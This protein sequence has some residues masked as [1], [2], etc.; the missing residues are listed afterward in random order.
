M[1][2]AANTSI[3][4]STGFVAAISVLTLGMGLLTG[5][6]F[7]VALKD[8]HHQ[9]Q[10]VK[11]EWGNGNLNTSNSAYAEGDSVPHR[12][13]FTGVPLNTTI[14][15][16]IRYE[17]T[18]G[19]K[20]AF[21]FL[22]SY[23]RTEGPLSV[24]GPNNLTSLNEMSD[25]TTLDIPKDGSIDTDDPPV[26]TEGVQQFTIYGSFSG[27]AYVMSGPSADG[28]D[29][30]ITI[31]IPGVTGEIL[32]A[33]GGHLAI[34]NQANWGP[35]NGAGSIS[36][37]PYHQNGSGFIDED[38]DL[39]YNPGEE[40]KFGAGDR[41]INAGAVSFIE[42]GIEIEKAT[43]GQDAD[44]PP[45]PYIPVGDSVTWTYVVTN[46]GNVTLNKVAQQ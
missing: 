14:V 31:V 25:R 1:D 41:S 20:Y 17:F 12:Y 19:G 11:L 24:F 22:T 23:D 18:R 27:P 33:W 8:Q 26:W 15:M 43:N 16:D 40:K 30:V 28:T 34:G 46:T 5:E 39:I 2:R 9:F 37:S 3:G 36:G 35:G 21:D 6:V 4:K 29:K 7:A 10:N 32:V 38:G 45:G 13:E 42:P 44:S